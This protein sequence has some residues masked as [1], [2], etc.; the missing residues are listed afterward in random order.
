MF[1]WKHL[2]TRTSKKKQKKAK[3]SNQRHLPV[4]VFDIELIL[5]QK[6]EWATKSSKKQWTANGNTPQKPKRAT[7]RNEKQQRAFFHF[8]FHSFASIPDLWKV[9][10][11]K[12]NE[13]PERATTGNEKQ[14]KATKSNKTQK[15]TSELEKPK[16][17][18]KDQNEQQK[19]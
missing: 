10:D 2:K 15:R 18:I 13:K 8:N 19:S 14:Q 3:T 12:S 5:F 16:W 7:T 6:Q 4:L 11:T 1:K 9:V 17:A